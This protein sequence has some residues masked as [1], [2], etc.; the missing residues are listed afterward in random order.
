M[1]DAGEMV[2]AGTTAAALGRA[3]RAARAGGA[4]RAG[5]AASRAAAAAMAEGATAEGATAA[6]GMAVVARAA[7]ATAAAAREAAAWEAAARAEAAPATTKSSSSRML[8]ITVAF[9]DLVPVAV[10]GFACKVCCFVQVAVSV[11]ARLHVL[12]RAAV[13]TDLHHR[14]HVLVLTVADPPFAT[15]T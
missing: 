11:G 6:A 12:A 8:P 7:A 1:R 13:W 3:E 9:T 15:F 5:E 14:A 2:L 4:A 10:T